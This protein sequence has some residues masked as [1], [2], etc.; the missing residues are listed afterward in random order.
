LARTEPSSSVELDKAWKT[1]LENMQEYFDDKISWPLCGKS[2]KQRRREKFFEKPDKNMLCAIHHAV[3]H[4]N[5]F[6]VQQLVDEH[7]CGKRISVFYVSVVRLNH[8]ML[9]E[10]SG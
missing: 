9:A 7:D 3:L 6:V 4:N 8:I 1:L 2:L 5:V 10:L